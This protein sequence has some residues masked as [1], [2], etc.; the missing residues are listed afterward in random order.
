MLRN[1]K[2]L[3]II[4]FIVIPIIPDK[5]HPRRVIDKIIP[6]FVFSL[7]LNTLATNTPMDNPERLE[8]KNSMFAMILTLQDGVGAVAINQIG[9]SKP[10]IGA[11]LNE[12]YQAWK[13]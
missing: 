8:Q 5:K 11:C 9:M 1:L 12:F 4:Y 3:S 2:F 10:E 7:A 13:Q 6:V